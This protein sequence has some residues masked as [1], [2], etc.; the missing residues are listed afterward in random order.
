MSLNFAKYFNIKVLKLNYIIKRGLYYKTFLKLPLKKKIKLLIFTTFN[1]L[2]PKSFLK[3]NKNFY[4]LSFYIVS[5][6]IEK[7]K[8]AYIHFYT[9]CL[10][11]V[12]FNV[13]KLKIEVIYN[14]QALLSTNYIPLYT[15]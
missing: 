3:Y 12:S 1:L 4:I 10:Y 2:N 9:V 11:I 14:K 5:F 8:I 13:K 6:N 7:L 15:L